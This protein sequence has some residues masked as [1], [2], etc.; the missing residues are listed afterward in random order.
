[1]PTTAVV[2]K[3]IAR[4]EGEALPADAMQATSLRNVYTTMP[5][6]DD[7]VHLFYNFID[8]HGTC[9]TLALRVFHD[10]L[11]TGELMALTDNLR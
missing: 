10:G 7:H 8:L 1:M 5:V 2:I 4:R 3:Q 6:C 11:V 9:R